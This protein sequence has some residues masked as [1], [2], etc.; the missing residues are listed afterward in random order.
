[1]IMLLTCNNVKI[2]VT[3]RVKVIL[4]NDEEGKKLWVGEEGRER[5]IEKNE[6]PFT[7]I[8]QEKKKRCQFW[9][10]VA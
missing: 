7:E 8:Y 4:Y 3:K 1:M 10:G 5:G 6:K 2:T 9:L